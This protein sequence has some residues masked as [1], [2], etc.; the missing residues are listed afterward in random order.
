MDRLK[1]SHRLPH[2]VRQ[3]V[4]AD[5]DAGVAQALVLA[6]QRQMEGEFVDHH[7]DHETDIGPAALDHADRRWRA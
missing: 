3:P 1:Q 2:Q 4:A 7:A 5:L 6:V